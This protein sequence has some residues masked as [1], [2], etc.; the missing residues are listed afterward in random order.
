MFGWQVGGERLQ[1]RGCWI[2][3]RHLV[4]VC[5]SGKPCAMSDLVQEFGALVESRQIYFAGGLVQVLLLSFGAGQCTMLADN[6][7]G[8]LPMR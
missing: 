3:P 7:S 5:L 2:A 4:L 8:K 1:I 6:L